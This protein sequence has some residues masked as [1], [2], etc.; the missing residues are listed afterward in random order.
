MDS[1]AC[2]R[3]APSSSPRDSY[4]LVVALVAL[5][6]LV[7]GLLSPVAAGASAGNGD[8]RRDRAPLEVDVEGG[9]IRGARHDGYRTFEG[10]PFSAPPLGDLRFRPPQPVEPW[11]GVR[12]ATAPASP[13]AQ[14]EAGLAG[15]ST[16]SIDEDC[17][18]LNVTTPAGDSARRSGLPVMVWIHGGSFRIGA[19]SIYDGSQL[20]VDGDVVVV[21][22][23]YRL[24]PLGFLA[25][26]D[27]GTESD[28]G[29]GNLGL[30]DMQAA[31]RWVQDN[32]RA[33]GGNPRQVTIFGESA[34]GVAVCNNLVAPGS[35]QLFRRAISQSASCTLANGT[36]EAGEAAGAAFAGQVGCGTATD[37]PACLRQVGVETLL[38]AWP[39][40]GPV[41]GGQSLPL[42]PAEAFATG[43]AHRVDL[44]HGN[45]LDEQRFFVPL[46]FP[47]VLDLT[48]EGYVAS[49]TGTF[50]SLAPAV[51]ERYPVDA[52][53][54]PVIALSTV[55]SDNG[56]ALATC[57]HVEAYQAVEA[58]RGVDV[59]AYQFRDR[60]AP[61][62]LDLPGFDEGAEHGTE[63]SYLFP[64]V[65]GEEL[66][67]EQQVLSDAMVQ[68]WTSFAATGRPSGRHLP[69][70]RTFQAGGEAMGLDIASQGGV[71]MIDVAAEANCE[72]WADLLGQ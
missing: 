9:T 6:G 12:D 24:G 48:P 3:S 55:Y 1:R 39:G 11:D 19:G 37:V 64:L 5:I 72:F 28:W 63:L 61:P 15:E 21:T 66:T 33:F 71:G 36:V 7:V 50:G 52:Y 60:T 47:G 27:L 22:I 29:S 67:A 41:T 49:I 70:W 17:L 38:D 16:A 2:A 69:R 26:S 14:R 20:A 44:M 57:Q 35:A 45:T 31:L 56:N 51:L 8:R 62:L 4:R 34:G 42:Q 65:L 58:Q 25:H 32:I 23:N 10:V 13:C 40:G 43:Q 59:Y 46:L 53:P 30:A 18:Y 68:Y 54:S